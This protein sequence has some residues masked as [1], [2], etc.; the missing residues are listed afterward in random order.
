MIS[1]LPPS[2][3]H[4]VL[5]NLWHGLGKRTRFMPMYHVPGARD[6]QQTQRAKGM[7]I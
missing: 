4:C 2:R 1:L 6:L 3:N 5:L 7:L